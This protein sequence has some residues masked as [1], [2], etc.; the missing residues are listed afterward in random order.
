MSFEAVILAIELW[1]S[2]QYTIKSISNCI[3]I[4]IECAII[5]VG[6]KKF[7]ISEDLPKCK[8]LGQK[9]LRRNLP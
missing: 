1:C 6:P 7:K 4:A 3:D 2:G 9:Q 8:E 5:E